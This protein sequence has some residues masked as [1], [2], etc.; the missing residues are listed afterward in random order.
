[1]LAGSG[2][3]PWSVLMLLAKENAFTKKLGSD[4]LERLKTV[5]PNQCR[6]GLLAAALQQCQGPESTAN[7][8]NRDALLN[9]HTTRVWVIGEEVR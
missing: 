2:W 5:Y 6:L 7:V 3:R 4:M 1:M 9:H 8:T